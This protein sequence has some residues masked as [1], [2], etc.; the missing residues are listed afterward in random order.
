MTALRCILALDLGTSAFKAAPV[1]PEGAIAEPVAV[2]Y[3][4]D[5]SDGRITC[6]PDR[7]FDTAMQ[8]LRRAAQSARDANCRVEAI[9]ISSQ[10]QTYIALDRAGIPLSDAVVWTDSR[11]EVEAEKLNRAVTDV[12]AHCGFLRFTGQQFLPKA[13]RLLGAD[14]VRPGAVGKLLLLNEYLTL[15]LTGEAYGDETNQGMG[16]FFDIARR[17]RSPLALEMA[18]VGRAQLAAVAPA[19][20]RSARLL[21]G[22]A[23]ALDLDRVPV[24]SCGNDQACAAAGVDLAPPAA[25]LCNFGTAMVAYTRKAALPVVRS[26]NQIAGI[27][28]LEAGYFLLALEPECGS[29]LAWL[30]ERVCPDEGIDSLVRNAQETPASRDAGAV[31][32]GML[33]DVQA[34]F[35]RMAALAGPMRAAQ[36]V[37]HAYRESFV[38]VLE[39]ASGADRASG[40]L[41]SSGGLSRSPAWLAFLEARV[42]AR[43]E[44]A[45]S[46]HPGLVGIARIIARNANRG[47]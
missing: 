12:P 28:P 25:V 47:K 38:R 20:A 45:G 30:A 39:A 35:E 9:G 24:Y 36:A 1:T 46:A 22:I 13:M 5:D 2:P 14:G 43:L 15:R 37:L 40:P 4:L 26:G 42:G 17:S 7:Y 29:V 41:V 27:D 10:A 21:A 11:A 32:C 31:Q 33:A 23:S 6:P 16:G 3:T 18:G 44:P 8:A 34:S 19:A